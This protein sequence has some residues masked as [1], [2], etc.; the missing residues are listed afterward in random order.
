MSINIIGKGCQ[1]FQLFVLP[2]LRFCRSI[3]K[4]VACWIEKKDPKRYPIVKLPTA[5]Q[6]A[7]DNACETYY[8][9]KLKSSSMILSIWSG[10]DTA[11]LSK[12]SL[13]GKGGKKQIEELLTLENFI[14][15]LGAVAMQ[16]RY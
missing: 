10:E 13:S 1:L 12:P 4:E 9:E 16:V 15:T 5:V 14:L 7:L 11:A 6:S 3:F 8:N 2:I